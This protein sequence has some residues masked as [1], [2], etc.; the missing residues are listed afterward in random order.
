MN[1]DIWR[2]KYLY[3]D[4]GRQKRACN[5]PRG[6][7]KTA[8]HWY[9]LLG[10]KSKSLDGQI[11]VTNRRLTVA[12]HRESGA[13]LE[14]EWWWWCQTA[15]DG[16]RNTSSSRSTAAIV[17]QMQARHTFG[18]QPVFC[19][20]RLDDNAIGHNGFLL[21]VIFLMLLLMQAVSGRQQRRRL[22]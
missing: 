3:R 4:I 10:I 21:A 12:M 19:Q 11:L 15:T 6:T 18:K 16:S 17:D 8:S 2:K 1:M 13:G 5:R 14:I 7:V 22:R 9:S 20:P